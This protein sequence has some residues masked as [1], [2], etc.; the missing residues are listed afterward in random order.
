MLKIRMNDYEITEGFNPKIDF[1][2]TKTLI[3]GDNC[4]NHYHKMME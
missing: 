1:S 4:F 3:K 2:R